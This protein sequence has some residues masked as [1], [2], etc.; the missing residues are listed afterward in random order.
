[1]I[2]TPFFCKS[3]ITM[4]VI[5]LLGSDYGSVQ[6]FLSRHQDLS[7]AAF[8]N[9]N[10]GTFDLPRRRLQVAKTVVFEKKG[11]E[12]NVE[13]GSKEYLAGFISSPIQDRTVPQRGSG[14]EQ[15]LKLGGMVTVALSILF[16]GFMANNGLL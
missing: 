10:T 9:I 15:A 13:V 6:A 4:V 3:A 14:V 16:L 11:E 8:K 2:Q 1:M 7:Y 5:C 12:E